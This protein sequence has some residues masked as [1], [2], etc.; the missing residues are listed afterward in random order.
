MK[1]RQLGLTFGL[2]A[3]LI[4]INASASDADS[5]IGRW[6]T[7]DDKTHEPRGIVRIFEKGGKLFGSIE[8]GVDKKDDGAVCSA[9]NDDRK[10]QPLNGLVIIRNMDRDGDEWGG[11]DIVDPDDGKV[12]R[13]KMH[14]EDHGT[15]LIARG[16]IGFSLLGRSQ[17]WVRLP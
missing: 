8:R 9:C 15:K 12:Y 5:P 7:F 13:L 1:I 17:T 10:D 16:F 6:R 14:L 4:T 3:S 11:G 2:L